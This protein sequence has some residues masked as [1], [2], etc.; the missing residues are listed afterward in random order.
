MFLAS[1]RRGWPGFS[2]AFA[3]GV[4]ALA[5]AVGGAGCSGGSSS[6]AAPALGEGTTTPSEAEVRFD[7]DGVL[8]ATLTQHV[9]VSI[10]VA[11]PPQPVAVWLDG[12]YV[13]A[14]LDASDVVAGADGRAE[15][16]L[17]APTVPAYFT[18]HAKLPSG[19]S[20]QLDVSV[21]AAGYGGLVLTP[22]YQGSRGVLQVVG[23][24]FVGGSCSDVLKGPLA[25]GA[26]LAAVTVGQDVTLKHVP[27]GVRLA[28]FVRSGH[29]AAGCTDVDAL[30]PGAS[31][32]VKVSLYDV[33]MALAKTNLDVTLGVQA[34]PADHDAWNAMLDAAATQAADAFFP[35]GTSEA[36]TLLDA[37]SALVPAGGGTG[38]TPTNATQF[39]VS[40]TGGTWDVKTSQWLAARP[41]TMHA[42]AAAWMAA[43]RPDAFG[44]LGV[45]LAP[46]PSVGLASVDLATFGALDANDAGFSTN[47][48]FGWLADST[49]GVHLSGSVD[50]RPTALVTAVANREAAAAV[51]GAPSVPSALATPAQI[52]CDGLAATLVGGGGSS[53]QGCD[54]GCTA[55]LCREALETRWQAARDASMT[56]GKEL[57]VAMT[58]SAHATV[59]DTAEPTGFD[60]AWVGQVTSTPPGIALRLGGP[61]HGA[62]AK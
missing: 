43:G 12:D 62:A 15:L 40:R 45:H 38:T 32:A 39:S 36:T 10:V 30:A 24:V 50:L 34:Q 37:M 47:V 1:V 46:G 8:T 56:A 59:G 27:A 3:V 54:V 4:A 11:S 60:G 9:G 28:A 23:S 2:A 33:P 57:H 20:A 53:Y 44:D 7:V 21:S 19:A 17:R 5:A 25:D 35:T 42:R 14:S 6:D 31:P 61:A 48:A 49:D 52:D 51:A 13:D 22:S 26:P 41:P 55:A 16:T 29:F 18:L 58:A